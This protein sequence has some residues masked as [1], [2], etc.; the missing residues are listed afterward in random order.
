MPQKFKLTVLTPER[1]FFEGDI[2]SL[3]VTTQTGKMGVLKNNIP[4]VTCIVPGSLSMMIDGVWKQAI[5]C[6]G[7]ME[8]RPDETIILCQ[9]AN[10][11]DEIVE[12]EIEDELQREKEI[13]RQAQSLKE[14]ELSKAALSRTFAK[15]RVKKEIK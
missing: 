12:E 11:P 6:D 10:W 8:V 3:I 13:A 4:L 9:I 5:I 7:F 15:L 1:N 14:Y 2:E